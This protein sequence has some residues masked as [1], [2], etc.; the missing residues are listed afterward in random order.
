MTTS[1]IYRS[2]RTTLLI[3]RPT[4]ALRKRR[5]RN[6]LGLVVV[7]A[8]IGVPAAVFG[9]TGPAYNVSEVSVLAL[10]SSAI[11]VDFNVTNVGNASGRPTCRITM[12][13]PRKVKS[14][15]TVHLL[16][17][18]PGDVDVALNWIVQIRNHAAN[19]ITA[20]DVAI[21]CS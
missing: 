14:T 2:P 8:V 1:R 15:R 6:F 19:K 17:V 9:S 5:V 16:R 21:S 7:L 10:S 3:T 12:T 11:N 4:H 20:R 13:G 18:K